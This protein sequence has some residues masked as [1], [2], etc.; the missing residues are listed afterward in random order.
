MFFGYG[1]Y[2]STIN[3]SKII[4]NSATD[5]NNWLSINDLFFDCKKRQPLNRLPLSGF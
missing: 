3:I 2:K 4:P 1:Y 5:R